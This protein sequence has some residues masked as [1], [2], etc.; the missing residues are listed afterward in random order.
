VFHH[1]RTGTEMSFEVPPPADFNAFWE[2]LA[3]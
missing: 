1:P 3:S 2:G